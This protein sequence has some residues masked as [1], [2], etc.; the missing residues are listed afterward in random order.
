MPLLSELHIKSCSPQLLSLTCL[1]LAFSAGVRLATMG[2]PEPRETVGVYMS[3]EWAEF[4]LAGN[5][6]NRVGS[7]LVGNTG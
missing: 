1:S 2:E 4:L 3:L 5:G 7:R 6:L